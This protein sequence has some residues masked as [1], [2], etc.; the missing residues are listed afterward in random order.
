MRY[1][2]FRW[3]QSAAKATR[4]ALTRPNVKKALWILTAVFG[5]SVLVGLLTLTIVLAWV[6]RDLP[7]PNTLLQRDVPQTTKIFDRTGNTLLYEI[8]GEENRTLV[9]LKDLPSFVGHATVSIEDKGFYTHKGVYWRGLVRA[10]L[11]SLVSGKRVGGTSTLTQQFVKNAVLTNERSVVRKLK[12]LLLSLQMERVYSKDQILQMYLNE[13]PYG[14]SI[15]GVES[16]AR[17]YFGKS[18]KDLSIDEAALLAS[19][20]QA[21]DL[22][23][24]YGT[25]S[26]GD[27]RKKLVGRQHYDLDLMAEQGYITQEQAEDA[28]KVDTLKKLIPKK[29]G[30]ILAPHFVM[31][32]RS[33]LIET[34]GQKTVESKGYKVITTLD[35]DKQQIAEDEIQKGVEARGE[36]YRFSNAALVSLDPK[37]GQIVSMV[38]SKDFFDTEHDGQVNVVLRPRQPG[39][40]FK[41]IVY[42]AGFIKGFLPETVLWDVNTVFKTEIKDYSPKNYDLK[43]HGP[44][45]LRTAL[46]G[47]LNIPAVKMI[48]LVGVGRVLD[49]AEELGYT[50]FADRSRFGLSLVL[51]G[52]EVKLLEHANAYASFANDGVQMPTSAILKVEDAS[53]QTLEEWKQPEGKRVM[54]PNI[55]ETVSDVLS[56]NGARAYVFGATNFLTLPSRPVAAKTGTTNNFHDAWTLGYVPSLV[57]GVWVGNNDNSEM[58][59][60][61][62]GSQIAAPIWQ[63]YMRRAL[64]KTP[65]ESF[66]KP[67]P[68]LSEGVTKAALLGKAHEAKIK[69]DTLSGKLATNLTPPEYI[70]ERSFRDAHSILYYVDKDDP[71]GPAPAN[72]ANDPQYGN[73][74]LAVQRWVAS[75]TWLSVTSTPPTEIDDIHTTSSQ[76]TVTVSNPSANQELT[77]R[78][79]TVEA[80]ASGVNRIARM[81]AWCEGNLIGTSVRSSGSVSFGEAAWSVPIQFPNTL[82]RGFHDIEVHAIDDVGNR[83]R[84]TVTVNL[85]AE[86]APLTLFISEPSAGTKLISSSFPLS[87]AVTANDISTAVRVDLFAQKSDGSSQLIG[88]DLTP[89]TTSI[90]YSWSSYPGVGTYVLFPVLTDTG[91]VT[92]SG[93]KATVIVE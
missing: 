49:F 56:D 26:Y 2:R 51:G 39:S 18:A 11:T 28:K 8:H 46:Q 29:I 33:L 91:G 72:P 83:G 30:N 66:K 62:D 42:A 87:I 19:L 50:T 58:K 75:S 32:V 55:A 78:S 17:N 13:I 71:R 53:G 5:G 37:T 38:G 15:Y 88:S 92:H 21:P 86:P 74:E 67:S 31:Y 45:S 7:D 23:S 43:E 52:G 77:T 12:E 60:G 89:K 36:K 82:A 14:S 1:P 22:Y 34:Y 63:G 16:A 85:N 9:E 90:R 68:A 4:N 10:F 84:A 20:P 79:A 64:E 48:Y 6:S 57:T 47:S 41:P 65:V 40:S 27:N 70:E 61:A 44:V 73:W 76:P 24:P 3:K 80:Q 59:K 54:E 93:E 35:W 25:G 81:E 69:I